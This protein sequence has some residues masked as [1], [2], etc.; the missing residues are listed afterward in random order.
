MYK[1]LSTVVDMPVGAGGGGRG[2]FGPPPTVIGVTFDCSDSAV[3]CCCSQETEHTVYNPTLLARLHST[4]ETY[5]SQTCSRVAV[6]DNGRAVSMLHDL[7]NTIERLLE[8]LGR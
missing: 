8:L 4:Y 7:I 5:N 1:L 2:W 3:N 6:D